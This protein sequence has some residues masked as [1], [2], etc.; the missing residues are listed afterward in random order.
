MKKLQLNDLKIESFVTGD[1]LNPN[2][3][4]GGATN[5]WKCSEWV[6]PSEYNT[7]W[8]SCGGTCAHTCNINQCN[9]TL[10]SYCQ[11]SIGMC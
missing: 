2:T 10:N 11:C 8:N 3:V 9:H 5:N 6:C 4:K 7:C 1:E